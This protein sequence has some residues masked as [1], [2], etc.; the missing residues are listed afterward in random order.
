MAFLLPH[1]LGLYDFVVNGGRER[2]TVQ[3]VGAF[4]LD[5]LMGLPLAVA[6]RGGCPSE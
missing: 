3:A 4:I 6:W 2:E 1:I 5:A